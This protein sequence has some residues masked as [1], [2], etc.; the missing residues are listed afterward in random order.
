MFTSKD[1]RDMKVGMFATGE[2]AD[3]AFENSVAM[4]KRDGVD[5][6]VAMTAILMFS[7]TL[8]ETLAKAVEK[9]EG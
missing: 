3:E 5:G 4:L 2:T 1:F 8:L 7:N 9:N 6:I